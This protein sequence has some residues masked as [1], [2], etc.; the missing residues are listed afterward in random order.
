MCLCVR[1]G[2]AVVGKHLAAGLVVV[3]QVVGVRIAGMLVGIRFVVA[4]VDVQHL[5]DRKP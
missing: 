2:L 3:A 5:P 4:P 1:H